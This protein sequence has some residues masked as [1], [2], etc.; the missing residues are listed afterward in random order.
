MRT[1][2]LTSGWIS[3]CNELNRAYVTAT[4][5]RPVNPS[6]VTLWYC[7]RMLKPGCGFRLREER[8]LRISENRVLRKIFGCMMVEVTGDWRKLHVDHIH[9]LYC[10]LCVFQLIKWKLWDGQGM[11]H[12]RKRIEIHMWLWWWNLKEGNVMEDL[13][14]DG[15]IILTCISRNRMEGYGLNRGRCLSRRT[16]CRRLKLVLMQTYV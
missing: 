10:S 4:L 16:L 3:L 13:D 7:R 12:V 9:D 6:Y 2:K 11:W 8:G 14:L 1:G 15:M 5:T